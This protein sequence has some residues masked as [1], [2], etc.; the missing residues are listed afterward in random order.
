M[1]NKILGW[2]GV[3]W[4]SLILVS[5]TARLLSGGASGGA[6]GAGRLVGF[7]FGGL[8]CVAGVLA[9]RKNPKA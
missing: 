2:I 3:V 5:G 6:Y 7:A 9:L 4:G 1:K 8:L